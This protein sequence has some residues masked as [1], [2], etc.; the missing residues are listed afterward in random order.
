MRSRLSLSLC[1]FLIGFLLPASVMQ[2]RFLVAQPICTPQEVFDTEVTIVWSPPIQPVNITLTGYE[3]WQQTDGGSWQMLTQVPLSPTA[4][5]VTSLAPN[6][7]YTFAVKAV[8]KTRTGRI[9][10]SSFGTNDA[11]APPCVATL[12]VNAPAKVGI[13][14]PS[15]AAAPAPGEVGF[16]NYHGTERK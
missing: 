7:T 15:Q 3:I 2:Q 14:V 11:S 6:H 1:C 4:Y 5:R 9:A 12:I 13:Q 16:T 10:V 8:G